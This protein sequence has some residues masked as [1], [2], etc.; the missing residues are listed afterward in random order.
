MNLSVITAIVSY[1]KRQEAEISYLN[2]MPR[3]TFIDPSTQID[4]YVI[5]WK[6]GYYY[7]TA[8]SGGFTTN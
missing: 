6:E 5:K 7:R 8:N 2:V 4:K 1:V 3:S